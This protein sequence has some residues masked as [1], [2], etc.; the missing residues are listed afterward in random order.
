MGSNELSKYLFS[1]I[2]RGIDYQHDIV[3]AWLPLL[4]NPDQF[5]AQTREKLA[6]LG[7]RSLAVVAMAAIE[8]YAEKLLLQKGTVEK[9]R[10][11]AFHNYRETIEQIAFQTGQIVVLESL[12]KQRPEL[13]P[14][15]RNELDVLRERKNE[16]WRFTA[17]A[18]KQILADIQ[19]QQFRKGRKG[20]LE[21]FGGR[22]TKPAHDYQNLRDA[23]VMRNATL[24]LP[25]SLRNDFT[26]QKKAAREVVREF[27]GRDTLRA[28]TLT[29][30]EAIDK[31]CKRINRKLAIFHKI[32]QTQ[33]K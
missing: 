30:G 29:L 24:L 13:E 1:E 8:Q 10:L 9:L 19:G 3:K 18:T 5:D 12:C 4:T 23:E 25:P 14:W 31:H 21:V 33:M 11:R 2:L 6:Q 15:V 22:G 28:G 26:S 7:S 27:V 17:S 16:I 20:R 32:H